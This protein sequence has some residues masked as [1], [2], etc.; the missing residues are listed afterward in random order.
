[1]AQDIQ[2]DAE[3]E[4]ERARSSL[5]RIF[6]IPAYHLCD[7][8]YVLCV[9]IHLIGRRQRV[10]GKP[11]AGTEAH[12]SVLPLHWARLSPRLLLPQQQSKW[13]ESFPGKPHR[14]LP[15]S[16]AATC[17]RQSHRSRGMSQPWLTPHGDCQLLQ[18]H[19]SMPAP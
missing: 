10:R 6:L 18:L 8:S 15:L 5:A 12:T 19:L 3:Q 16:A 4:A 17:P 2:G 1:M 7:Q 14:L 9:R 11:Q 13:T